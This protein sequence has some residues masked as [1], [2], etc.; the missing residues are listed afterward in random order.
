MTARVLSHEEARAFYD[1]FGRKQDLQRI[2]ED[3]AIEVLLKY[4]GFDSARA[5]VELGC[6]TGRLATR[7]LEECLPSDATYIGFDISRTMLELAQA[8]V[9]PFA[10]RAEVQL[11]DG[12]PSLAV[13]DNTSDR[14]LSAYVLDLLSEKEIRAALREAQRLLV[15]GGLLCLASL[16][17]GHTPVS[18]LVC[19]S[20]TAIH[21]LNPRMVGGCRP[22]ELAAFVGP[23][24]RIL[25]REVV[26]TVGICTEVLVAALS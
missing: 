4:A 7:L 15:P 5:V 14:F 20:W 10:G 22:L 8:R 3:P 17:F 24:W 25:H 23:E 16:T 18:R 21:S 19:R 12:S 26:C 13:G 11:T 6:G 9:A 1:R 2:Y